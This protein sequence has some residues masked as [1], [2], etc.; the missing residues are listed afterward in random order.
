MVKPH[1]KN[2]FKR[3]PFRI[4][5]PVVLTVLLFNS[6][7]R[8]LVIWLT[9]PLAVVGVAIGLLSSNLPLTFP[10]LL[11]MLSLTGMI[12]KNGIVLVDQVT[13]RSVVPIPRMASARY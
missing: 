6:L 7:R 11:A 9:V 3:I 13:A 5:L 2:M 4:F 1:I 12:L 8:S 10:A